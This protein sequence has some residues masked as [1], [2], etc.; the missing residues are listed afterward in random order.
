MPVIQSHV[1]IPGHQ[2]FGRVFYQL[3]HVVENPELGS[4]SSVEGKFCRNHALSGIWINRKGI[5]VILFV[6]IQN[7]QVTFSA[8]VV[9]QRK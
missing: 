2:G 6:V 5:L 4:T 3:T 7:N 9:G 8:L 1:Q